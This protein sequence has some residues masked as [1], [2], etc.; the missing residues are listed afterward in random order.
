MVRQRVLPCLPGTQA[1]KL[2]LLSLDCGFYLL[3]Q[4]F[5]AY[6]HLVVSGIVGRK[7]KASSF[8][9]RKQDGVCSTSAQRSLTSAYH[10]VI[11]AEREAEKCSSWLNG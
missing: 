2:A 11:L 1:S 4:G 7:L 6:P 10:M 3:V 9:F 5:L 8:H